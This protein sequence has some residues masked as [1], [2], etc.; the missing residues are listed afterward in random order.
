MHVVAVE[1]GVRLG[2]GMVG[3]VCVRTPHGFALFCLILSPPSIRSELV[4]L[5]LKKRERI[6][7]GEGKRDV[8][9]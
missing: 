2:G 3:G 6:F 8:E 7:M 4:L 5:A 1:I 9:N